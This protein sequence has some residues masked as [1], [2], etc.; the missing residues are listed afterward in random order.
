LSSCTSVII[1]IIIIII[2]SL[3]DV[4]ST[5]MI[6]SSYFAFKNCE[7]FSVTAVLLDLLQFCIPLFVNICSY[8]MLQVLSGFVSVYICV[9][10]TSNSRLWE[11]QAE[12]GRFSTCVGLFAP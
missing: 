9:V 1:I 2:K 10:Q 3:R 7:G 8:V 11:L 6:W 4:T 5:Q 12:R